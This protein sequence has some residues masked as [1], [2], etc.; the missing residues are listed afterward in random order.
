[1]LEALT[2]LEALPVL[3]GD[4]VKP[5][6]PVVKG[7]ALV[8]A[9]A[10]GVLHGVGM[11]EPVEEWEAEASTEALEEAEEVEEVE[12]SGELPLLYV[13]KEDTVCREEGMGAEELTVREGTGSAVEIEVGAEVVEGR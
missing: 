4:L 13:G 7:A 9:V 5:I 3:L 8:V 12:G 2:V 11:G 6:V 1:M 10:V